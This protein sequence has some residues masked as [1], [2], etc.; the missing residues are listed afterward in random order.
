MRRRFNRPP[1]AL[2]QYGPRPAFP[3][4]FRGDEGR[5]V[6]VQQPQ[7]DQGGVSRIEI[8]VEQVEFLIA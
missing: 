3:E 8:L 4:F 2:R 1:N 5:A 7:A 6:I